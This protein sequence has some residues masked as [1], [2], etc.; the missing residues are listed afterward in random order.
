M[1]LYKLASLTPTSD[2]KL[3]VHNTYSMV[4]CQKYFS[5]VSES[6][7]TH[8]VLAAGLPLMVK[9]ALTFL[10]RKWMS[11]ASWAISWR[12]RKKTESQPHCY[13][14]EKRSDVWREAA[15]AAAGVSGL[16]SH[17]SANVYCQDTATE[18]VTYAWLPP[19]HTGQISRQENK[20][21][22]GLGIKAQLSTPSFHF[23]S[24]L[25]TTDHHKTHAALWLLLAKLEERASAALRGQCWSE[26][27]LVR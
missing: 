3:A 17:S 14:Q 18:A 25:A 8:D 5:I 23:L 1:T 24:S 9:V 12:L 26:L 22:A 21:Q 6:S 4:C 11:Q 16:G 15:S 13:G 7:R 10:T 27:K 2:N 19:S 20:R